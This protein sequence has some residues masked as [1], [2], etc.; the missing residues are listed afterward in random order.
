MRQI[1]KLSFVLSFLILVVFGSNAQTLDWVKTTSGSN[2]QRIY[3]TAIDFG[4]NVISTGEFWGTTDFD[5][6][7]GVLNIASQASAD[8]FVQKYDDNGSLLWVRTFGAGGPDI[9]KAVDVDPMGNIYVTGSFR[10]TVDF[11]PGPGLVELTS[12][13]YSDIFVLKLNAN[14]DLIWARNFQSFLDFSEGND[15]EVDDAGNVYTTGKMRGNVD[16]DPGA[17]TN[18]IS[19]SGSDIFIHKLDANGN[20]LWVQT[21]GGSGVWSEEGQ[22]LELD[23]NQHI[24]ISGTFVGTVDFDSGLGINNLTALGAYANVFI[25]K[26]KPNGGF[27]WAKGFG[28]SSNLFPSGEDMAINDGNLIVVGKFAGAT[29]F[30]PGTGVF[31]IDDEGSTDLYVEKLDTAGN[32]QWVRTFGDVS[33]E[34][35]MGVATDYFNNIYVTGGFGGTVDFDPDINTTF[36]MISEGNIDA[37]VLKL[38]ATGAFN[39]AYNLG[40]NGAD[41]GNAIHANQFGT[42][43]WIAGEFAGTVDFDPTGITQNVSSLGLSDGFIQK[44]GQAVGCIPTFE[45]LNPSIC[46]GSNYVAPSGNMTWTQSGLYSDTLTNNAGC[47]SIITIDLTVNIPVTEQ[48]SVSICNGETYTSPSGNFSWTQ[49]GSYNDTVVS[50]LT[51][52]DSIISIDLIVNTEVTEQI[53]VSICNGETYI[54]PSGNSSWMQAGTYFDTLTSLVSGCDSILEI[55]LDLIILDNT[56]SQQ[57]NTLSANQSNAAYQWLDCN[58]FTEVMGETNSVF[59]P[60]TNGDYAVEVTFQGCID[61]SACTPITTIGLNENNLSRGIVSIFPNPTNGI[62]TIQIQ[63]GNDAKYTLFDTK[64][65]VVQFGEIPS[66]ISTL[67]FTTCEAGQY[68]LHVTNDRVDQK[69]NVFIKP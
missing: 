34:D 61:T 44:I 11:D 15:I 30:D 54:S 8:I 23:N 66:P 26:L 32:F 40:D 43:L 14:G 4:D 13:G 3:G 45:Q 25:L 22:A 56:A 16:F 37:Y 20:F 60:L 24:Y 62:V 42:T 69:L 17:G 35:G 29:D 5:P 18:T 12:G 51:G 1:M 2:D 67:N 68:I 6:N 31:T 49:T 48:I 58:G 46:S 41:K 57:D 39:W 52:C 63:S 10:G 28:S 47:D 9:G 64:G 33:I 50:S 7:A 38:D 36:N 55:D 21:F 19:A 65:R 53:S 27:G 59:N